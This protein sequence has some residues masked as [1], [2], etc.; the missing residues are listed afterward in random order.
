MPGGGGISKRWAAKVLVCKASEN[1][2][3]IQSSFNLHA[4][5]AWKWSF[6]GLSRKKNH[7]SHSETM[8]GLVTGTVYNQ[9]FLVSLV[10]IICWCQQKINSKILSERLLSERRNLALLNT[11]EDGAGG[12]GEEVREWGFA[13]RYELGCRDDTHNYQQWEV[14]CQPRR[15]FR[16]VVQ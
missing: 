15:P 11:E 1:I 10:L 6:S 5:T 3:R 7:T 9:I 14:K 13:A 16:G 2:R 4:V 12:W 8:K